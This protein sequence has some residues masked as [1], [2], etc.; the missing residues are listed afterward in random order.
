MPDGR[1]GDLALRATKLAIDGVV[2]LG[3]VEGDP[4]LARP[5]S[6]PA[7]RALYGVKPDAIQGRVA[8]N[9]RGHPLLRSRTDRRAENRKP[10]LLRSYVVAARHIGRAIRQRLRNAARQALLGEPLQ[11]MLG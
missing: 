2:D 8:L 3:A 9:G 10:R 6:N 11:S 4:G 7:H 5:S 1:R